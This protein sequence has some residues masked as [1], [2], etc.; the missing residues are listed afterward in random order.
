MKIINTEW[1]FDLGK[2][3]DLNQF[4]YLHVKETIELYKG[5][6]KLEANLPRSKQ[7]YKDD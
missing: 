5:N 1:Y 3:Y 7:Y 6:E 2:V 4:G